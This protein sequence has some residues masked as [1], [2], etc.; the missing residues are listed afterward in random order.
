MTTSTPKKTKIAIRP[1]Q[2][3]D[4]E[5]IE[6]LAVSICEND[7]ENC[8]ITF[9]RQLKQVRSWYGLLK[10]LSWFPNPFEH[11]FHVYVARE[12]NRLRGL[13]QVSPFNKSGTTWQV[14]RTIEDDKTTAIELE[15]PQDKDIGSMLLRHCFG[16]IFQART[17]LSEVNIHQKKTLALYRQNGFH[18][19]AQ[20]TYWAI[21]PE[22]IAELANRTVDLPNLLGVSNLDAQILYKLHCASI[23][24]HAL[25]EVFDLQIQDFKT[26]LVDDCLERV[27][28][29][30]TNST[31]SQG[32]VF[33]PQRKEA[34]G[35]FKLEACEDGSFPHI[36]ELTIH[37]GYEWLYPKLLAKMARLLKGLPPQSLQVS[38]TD[39][40][41][42]R[43]QYL[44]Q[45]G[46]TIVECNLL[47]SRSVWHKLK[48]PK[49]LESLQWSEVL[50]SLQPARTPIP[51]RISFSKEDYKVKPH[52]SAVD[53]DSSNVPSQS[54]NSEKIETDELDRDRLSD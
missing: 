25:R 24:H 37:P 28:E 18:P 39:Y 51:S 4:L 8:S 43:Q 32:Y 1:V 23:P 13:I 52:K 10:F 34:I 38:S 11:H 45:L 50:K 47:M 12:K 5:A 15:S 48:E 21:A 2:Y 41:P 53:R 9:L 35:Y 6:T 3:R 46:A 36:G 29:F 33:E 44:E 49:P 22:L 40:Q 54:Q 19:L 42:N 31:I 27:K 16:N 14:E 26:T 30:F 7:G 17:W 20:V